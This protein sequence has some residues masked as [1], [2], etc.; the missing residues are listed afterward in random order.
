M[1]RPSR[2]IKGNGVRRRF[3]HRRAPFLLLAG[4]TALIWIP[5]AECAVLG[6]GQ[7][8]QVGDAAIAAPVVLAHSPEESIASIQFNLYYDT[9][10]FNLL[11]VAPGE[12]AAMAG[13]D[14]M[15][16]AH[17]GFATVMIAGLNQEP[18]EEGIL[19]IFY[20]LP[21]GEQSTVFQG[22]IG[23]VVF[24]N[25]AGGAVPADN[26]EPEK[27]NDSKPADTT[28]SSDKEESTSGTSAESSGQE[29]ADSQ[30][31]ALS[32]AWNG[33]P[34]AYDPSARKN[35]QAFQNDAASRRLKPGQSL[36]SGMNESPSKPSSSRS[37]FAPF[38]AAYN[39]RGEG[40]NPSAGGLSR[41]AAGRAAN[42]ERGG[43]AERLDLRNNAAQRAQIARNDSP[44]P[45]TAAYG[46]VRGRTRSLLHNDGSGM[47]A[48][49]PAR[50]LSAW[51]WIAAMFLLAGMLMFIRARLFRKGRY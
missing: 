17:Q 25:P 2:Q 9:S 12:A 16:G 34:G 46:A 44:M 30:A 14:A 26:P 1:N 45:L 6:L 32:G 3:F 35:D 13:K 41:G 50:P 20:F 47:L 43:F 23:A 36:R 51:I 49:Q 37:G 29:S 8:S 40:A 48:D 21:S 39:G 33:Y 10:Q 28:T 15:F 24:A 19:A 11:D 18:I 31:G 27:S 4:I 7:P 22:E 38:G 42:Q 5:K